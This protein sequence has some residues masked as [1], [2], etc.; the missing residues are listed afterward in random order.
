MRSILMMVLLSLGLN[1][2]GAIGCDTRQSNPA[3]DAPQT[4]NK[5]LPATPTPQR[6]VKE[7][8]NGGLKVLAEGWQSGVEDAFVAVARD[9]ETYS[10]LRELVGQLP[11]MSAD[12]FR[13]NVVIA[14][15]LGNRNTGGYTVEIARVGDGVIRLAESRPPKDAIVTQ[16]L[17]TPF[18]VVSMPVTG[19]QPLALEMEGEWKTMTRPFRVSSG[20]FTVTGGIIGSTEEFRLEGEIGMMRHGKLATFVFDLKAASETKQRAL[21]DVA[22]GVAQ[23]DGGIKITRMTAG[24]LLS[25]PRGALRADGKLDGGESNLTLSFESLPSNVSDGY[26]GRGRM[27]ATGSK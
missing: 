27:E 4:G 12:D 1:S 19:E 3:Q 16:S 2:A 22:T 17:T 8:A 5:S 7:D 21:K 18:K 9:A 6:E 10:R 24:A 14:A 20:N 15:F 13:T 25:P 11:E 26:Q 23:P